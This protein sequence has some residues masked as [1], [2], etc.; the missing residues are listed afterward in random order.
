[1]LILV[2]YIICLRWD[3]Q[4]LAVAYIYIVLLT[5]EFH[6]YCFLIFFE[7]KHVDD[8]NTAATTV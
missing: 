3:L 4:L 6:F 2:S 7:F 8:F 1:V 5:E